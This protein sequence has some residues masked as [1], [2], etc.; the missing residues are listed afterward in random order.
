VTQS[1]L[2]G[3]PPGYART[4]L[5]PL[6]RGYEGFVAKDDASPEQGRPTRS[7]LKVKQK[8]WTVAEDGWRRR[9]F[10]EDRR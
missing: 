10:E 9:I 4:S 3:P 1:V 8:N 2:A 5:L 7:W 6:E